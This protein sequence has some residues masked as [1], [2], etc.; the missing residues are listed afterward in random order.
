MVF[1][2]VLNILFPPSS[3]QVALQRLDKTKPDSLSI[4]NFGIS[5]FEVS[6]LVL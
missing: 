4:L 5:S 6:G 3:E 1:K 2:P